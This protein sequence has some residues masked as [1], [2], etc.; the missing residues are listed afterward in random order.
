MSRSPDRREPERV[1]PVLVPCLLAGL[2]LLATI[3]LIGT[4][5]YTTVRY[6]V[7]IL[8]LIV[9]VI[10]FQSGRGPWALP[11]LIPAVLW[12]PVVPLDL[13]RLV[14]LIAHLL[15]A[16]LFLAVG[17]LLRAPATDARGR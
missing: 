7:S 10:A 16:A 2:V 4:D 15:A 9:V 11:L 6:V 12:N 3:P 5:W 8:A 1:R 14:L 13:A 17:V